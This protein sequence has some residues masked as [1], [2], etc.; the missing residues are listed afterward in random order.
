LI[1]PSW[2]SKMEI[3]SS[4]PFLKLLKLPISFVIGLSDHL[5]YHHQNKKGKPL[6]YFRAYERFGFLLCW[7]CLPRQGYCV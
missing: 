6:G 7:P 1:F 4:Y 5:N 3:I 2:K